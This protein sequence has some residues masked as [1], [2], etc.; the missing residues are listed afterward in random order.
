[1]T[2]INARSPVPKHV[3]LRTILLELI[4]REL[5]ADAPLPSE[6]ELCSRYGLSR[7][8]V[9]QALDALE[10]EHRIYRVAGK[11]SFVSP[12]KIQ[13]NLALT[14]FTEDMRA[15]GMVP[16]SRELLHETV[17][18]PPRVAAQLDLEPGEPVHVLRRL[19]I[20]D[21]T[22]MALEQTHIPERVA[23]GLLDEPLGAS[24]Y[25]TLAARYGLLPNR[26]EETIEADGADAE[27]A[28]LLGLQPGAPVLVL[29]RRTWVG[30][31]AIEY[32]GSIYRADRYRLRAALEPPGRR[33]AATGDGR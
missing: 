9:R 23:P 26:G 28:R 27:Q 29:E 20:A 16:G 18:A 13:M 19:R 32:V 1:M 17:P 10:S 4:E 30:A 12:P 11:G 2:A 6:R 15:R 22:A 24:L 8:T 14:S 3:Q 31:T 25:E 21:G 7:M 33:P 5:T